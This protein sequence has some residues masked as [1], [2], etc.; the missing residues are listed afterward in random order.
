M[1]IFKIITNVFSTTADVQEREMLKI[2]QKESKENLDLLKN[3][4]SVEQL[5][6]ELIGYNQYNKEIAL[7]KIRQNTNYN[8]GKTKPLT[9]SFRVAASLLFILVA[10]YFLKNTFS[11][12]T[13]DQLVHIATTSQ[14]NI[15]LNDGTEVILDTQSELTEES[16]RTTTLKGRAY[17]NVTPDLKNTF[18]IKT[19]AGMISVLGTAFS[20]K[21]TENQTEV[22]VTEGKVKVQ[23]SEDEKILLKDDFVVL[24]QQSITIQKLKS[25]NYLGWISKSVIF[26]DANIQKVAA[27]LSEFYNT[28]IVV[29]ENIIL[30]DCKINTSFSNETLTEALDELKLITGLNYKITETGIHFLSVKC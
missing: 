27:D 12:K 7:Q 30:S 25:E 20:L 4:I 28:K 11:Q 29:N 9:T 16:F 15:I 10:G 2:W 21:T 1:K 13:F 5:S 23:N 19:S 8:P 14:K 26:K 6:D 22:F 3:Q 24:T 18:V 17:F